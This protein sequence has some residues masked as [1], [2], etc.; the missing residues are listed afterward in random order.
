MYRKTNLN[1]DAVV[2]EDWMQEF[3]LKTLEELKKYE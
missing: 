1:L 3:Y 2:W